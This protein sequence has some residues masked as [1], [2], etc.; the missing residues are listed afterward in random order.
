[1]QKE[2]IIEIA[3][4]KLKDAILSKEMVNIRANRDLSEYGKWMCD[5]DSWTQECQHEIEIAKEEL[6][7]LMS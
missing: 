1:M 2:Q 4:L 5:Y 3:V 6:N 7:S